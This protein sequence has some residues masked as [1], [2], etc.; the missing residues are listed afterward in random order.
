MQAQM[1][2]PTKLKLAGAT[3]AG[4]ALVVGLL[5]LAL[6]RGGGGGDGH[7]EPA[8][9]A[10]APAADAAP[11]VYD[12]T[13]LVENGVPAGEV[14]LKEPRDPVWAD[15]VEGVIGGK[16]RGDL[17]KLVPGSTLQIVCK[18]LSCLIGVDAPEDKR[19]LATAVTKLIM[20][21]PLQVDVDPEEDGTQRWLFLTEPRM[22]SPQ[23][24]TEWYLRVRKS[25]FEGIK[26][27]K[28]E[29]PLPV[30]ADQ[31]PES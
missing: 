18:T 21:G 8:A 28:R 20:L 5:A 26:A 11:V 9:A 19:P 12:P 22:T 4:L 10:K 3:L 25:T 16:M 6:G 14:F 23:V 31:L 24:F 29:N 1:A 15:V 13:K 17:E 27:G 2:A 7:K 30:P